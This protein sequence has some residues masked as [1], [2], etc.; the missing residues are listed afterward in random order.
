MDRYFIA[1]IDA[2]VGNYPICDRQTGDRRE[3]IARAYDGETAQRIVALLNEDDRKK[4]T[5]K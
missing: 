3:P 5:A 2:Y 1:N 4:G